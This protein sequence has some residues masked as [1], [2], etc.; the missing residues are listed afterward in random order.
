[1]ASYRA[2]PPPRDPEALPDYLQREL[3]RIS[4]AFQELEEF[5]LAIRHNE[6]RRP[7]EGEIAFADGTNW[8]PGSGKGA[9]EYRDG[10]WFKL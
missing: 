10:S 5:R 1:M 7:R 9:Y 4:L 2:E 3:Q 8:D 6:P